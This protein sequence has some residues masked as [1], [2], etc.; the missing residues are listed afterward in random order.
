MRFYRGHRAVADA[1]PGSGVGL[2]IARALASRIGGEVTL[3]S[4]EGGVITARLRLPR[5]V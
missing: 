2:T 4:S 1:A 5:S 3:A